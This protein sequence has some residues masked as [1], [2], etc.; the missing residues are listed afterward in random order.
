MK[1]QSYIPQTQ[2]DM[3]KRY[4]FGATERFF[5]KLCRITW[6]RFLKTMTMASWM[7]SFV[8]PSE[9]PLKL[10]SDLW[11]LS[12]HSNLENL[13]VELNYILR[14]KTNVP[15]LLVNLSI[16]SVRICFFC[17]W[18]LL[19]KNSIGWSQVSIVETTPHLRR[20]ETGNCWSYLMGFPGF[21][22]K[23]K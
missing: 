22:P 20:K 1:F 3:Q 7:E 15:M 19:E 4:R 12:I 16:Y 10:Y 18:G 17:C 9:W 6:P 23:D 2:Q 11:I 13:E 5:R 21:L 8:H 14:Y